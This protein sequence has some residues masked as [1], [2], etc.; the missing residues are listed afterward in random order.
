MVKK[1]DGPK[2]EDVLV[3]DLIAL[4][5]Q[6][7]TPWR[8]E[9]NAQSSR[10]V[11]FLTDHLYSGSNIILLEFGMCLREEAVLPFWCGA[12]EAR[13]HNVFPKKGS[14]SVRIL[15]PQLN[16]REEENEDGDTIEK[17]WT[18]FKVVP[19]FNVC[20]LQGETLSSLIDDATERQ[21]FG[22]TQPNPAA[23]IEQA[24]SFLRHWPV[25]LKHQ[26][27]RAFYSPSG[28]FICLPEF[29]S[30]HSAE[31]YYST[32]AH[33]CIHSTGHQSRLKRDLSGSFGTNPYAFEELVAEL[34][35]VLLCNQLQ[36][37]SDFSNHAAYLQ[38]WVSMLKQK[39]SI[40]FQALSHSR[41]AV[42]LINQTVAS[43]ESLVAA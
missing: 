31:A 10:H 24:E 39:P 2:P 36:I 32:R 25:S 42:E 21:G 37:S 8:K 16:K 18:S 9:W 41:K 14:R 40:L 28:D 20:D 30:F 38:S 29:E 43:Q 23:R 33:E 13:K 26:G 11:N 19:V 15:R 4:M 22:S 27:S 34:G 12:A 1:Y 35:S 5:E 7:K 3:Q 17:T 6:G